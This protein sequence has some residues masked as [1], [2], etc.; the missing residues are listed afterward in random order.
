MR[1]TSRKKLKA[2]CYQKLFWPF[3]IWINC[4]SDQKFFLITRTIL[5]TKYQSYFI[6]RCCC[7]LCQNLKFWILTCCK[8]IFHTS[9]LMKNFVVV[10]VVVA[11][12]WTFK[13]IQIKNINYL[14]GRI[15][16]SNHNHMTQF[17]QSP[18][19]FPQTILFSVCKIFTIQI[20][21][22][23]YLSRF[24]LSNHTVHITCFVV[25]DELNFISKTCFSYFSR[26]ITA[27]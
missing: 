14:F 6:S 18:I 3:T 27:T 10:V 17:F 24:F 9:S 22:T 16:L 1:E 26:Q 8:S 23:I 12:A 5:V 13:V 15:F 21:S 20:A 7:G 19:F 11:T 2:F 4:S 25:F